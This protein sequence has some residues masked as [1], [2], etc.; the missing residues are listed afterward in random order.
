[1]KKYM[2]LQFVVLSAVLIISL[3][4]CSCTSERDYYDDIVIELDDTDGEIIIR[5]WSFL[6]GSGAEIYYRK[7]NR[8][9]LLGEIRGADDGWCPFKA[10][11]YEVNVTDGVLSITWCKKPNEAWV[12]DC[13]DLEKEYISE[14]A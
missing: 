11:E 12:K 13:F 8:E 1:M 2:Y 3:L 7:D 6:L 10:G 4:S 14:Y 5:E 9:D